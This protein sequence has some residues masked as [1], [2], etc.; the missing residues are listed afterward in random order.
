MC[1]L[2]KLHPN[3]LS[4]MFGNCQCFGGGGSPSTSSD[5][6]RPANFFGGAQRNDRFNRA[7]PSL[8]VAPLRL[9]LRKIS[10]LST[11]SKQSHLN[12]IVMSK[13]DICENCS[14]DISIW[15]PFFASMIMRSLARRLPSLS[16][17]RIEY[18]CANVSSAIVPFRTPSAFSNSA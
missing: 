14:T 11:D 13:R 1:G 7:I 5:K 12:K 6:S 17:T 9:L 10:N 3:V 4:A 18:C 15:L 16:V 8:R 2:S